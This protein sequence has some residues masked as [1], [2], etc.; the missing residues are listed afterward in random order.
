MRKH[1]LVLSHSDFTRPINLSQATDLLTCDAEADDIAT[2]CIRQD[3]EPWAYVYEL[4]RVYLPHPKE[5]T[6]EA[7][8]VFVD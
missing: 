2:E 8:I 5:P 6:K 1:W 4:K 3:R 7:E